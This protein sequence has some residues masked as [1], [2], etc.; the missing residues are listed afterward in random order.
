M[1]FRSIPG[2]WQREDEVGDLI[3]CHWK[4]KTTNI[5][6]CS[7]YNHQTTISGI[8]HQPLA[9]LGKREGAGG[10]LVNTSCWCFKIQIYSQLKAV[11][12]YGAPARH[13]KS[14]LFKQIVIC[15]NKHITI[16]SNKL[17]FV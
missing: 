12:K 7:N 2:N 15:S 8:I 10:T 3:E 13:E 6:N 9:D 1:G 4:M 16:C 5:I 17:Q 11:Q 14:Y